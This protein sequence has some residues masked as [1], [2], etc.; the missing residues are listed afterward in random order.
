MITTKN[1]NYA[2]SHQKD[3][4]YHLEFGYAIIID[5]YNRTLEDFLAHDLV[6]LILAPKVLKDVVVGLIL[7]HIEIIFHGDI[8]Q[9]SIVQCVKS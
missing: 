7:L 9:R 1:L 5:F 2:R 6:D 8:K 4:I 3:N